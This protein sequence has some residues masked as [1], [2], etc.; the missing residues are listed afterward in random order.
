VPAVEDLWTERSGVRIH[1]LDNAPA[2]PTGLPLVFVPGLSDVADE[3]LE[4]LEDLAPRRTLVVEVRGRGRSDAPASGYASVDHAADVRAVLDEAGIDRFHLM[5]F[6]RGTT[7]A[8]RL[9]FERP[10]RVASLAIGD[11]L[12]EEVALPASFVEEHWQTRFRGRPMSD[13][14][15]HHVLDG[16]IRS[17]RPRSWWDDLTSLPCPLLVARPD[18][19]GIL[20][21]A[22]IARYRHVRPD[23][24]VLT[25]PDAGHDLFRRDRLLYPRAVADFIARRTGD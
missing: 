21:D 9:A 5:T 20:D 19:P 18:G 14:L 17:S 15:P 4:L 24:E 2:T 23:V 7:W 25:V 22:A 16:V 8:L 11:Y 12:P 13:R 3:Y 10:E 1:A 6:S